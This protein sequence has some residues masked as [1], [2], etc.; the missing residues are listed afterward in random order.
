[1][2]KNANKIEK[3]NINQCCKKFIKKNPTYSLDF[4]C[5]YVCMYVCMYN[6]FSVGKIYNNI[7]LY[8]QYIQSPIKTNDTDIK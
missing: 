3:T 1:M 7:K 5:M 2:A 4:A 8:L 6:L